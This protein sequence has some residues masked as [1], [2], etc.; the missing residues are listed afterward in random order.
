[1]TT[2]KRSY[3][4]LAAVALASTF[5]Q[6]QFPRV[7]A[8][9]FEAKSG[10][11]TW[12]DPATPD[13]RQTYVSSRGDTWELVMSDEFNMANRS[14]ASGDDHI[15]TSLE[16]P[17]GV[18]AALEV[19]SHNMTSTA[20][21]DDGTCY[22][23]IK[24]VDEVTNVTVWND[25]ASP[26][27]YE[28]VT[29]YYRSGM[30]QSWNKFC[31]QGG[32]VE[33]RAQLPG[34]VSSASGNPDLDGGSSARAE[35]IK[36][37][38]TWPGIWMMGN[39][40][41]AIFSAST[42]RMWPFSYDKCD[43]AVFNSTNQRISACD[44]DP[45][46]GLN[47]NQGRGA[48]EIDILEGG[49]SA[50]S[51]SVQVGPGMPTDF[52]TIYPSN[53]SSSSCI[54]TSTCE[55]KGA[56]APGIPAAVYE[57]ARPDHKTWYQGMRYAANNFCT[58]SSKLKQSYATVKAALAKGVT[59]NAC[60][61][62]NCPASK[63]PNAD[64]GFIDNS[65]TTDS[66]WGINSNGTCFSILNAY[67][68]AYLC[69]P[70][71]PSAKCEQSDATASDTTVTF[72]YQMDAL[73]ANWD[74]H[75]A[76]Y[77]GYLVY[78][79]EWVLG[80]SDGYI[81]WML[82]GQPIFEIPAS[83]LTNPSQD[84]AKSNPVKTMIAEPMYLILNVALSSTWGATPPNAGSKCRGDGTDAT[85]NKICDEF[86]M[87]MKIDYIR[88]YQDTASTNSSMAVGCDPASHPTAQWIADHIDAYQD[89]DN[90]AVDV[91]GRAF[92]TVDDDCTISSNKTK[93]STGSCV[94]SRCKCSSSS[95]TGPRCTSTLSTV[96]GNSSG[97]Y[98][99]PWYVALGTSALTIFVSL[100][101][102]YA[103]TRA[104]KKHETMRKQQQRVM[105]MSQSVGSV[106]DALS[107]GKAPP[108][109]NDNVNYS[110][111]FV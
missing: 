10:I 104:D 78:Q 16:K 62:T 81:R 72:E 90:Q 69:S 105:A 108:I 83:T 76:A 30:V 57:A 2:S 49:G 51:A 9:E 73:S 96:D 52:R 12:V 82:E 48:P 100:L 111:N 77:T 7:D 79:L 55:T 36:Y 109:H 14:F 11:R 1:M 20:C 70:G 43:D 91:S 41:R 21:D 103:T 98:G 45:G 39:L 5:S 88:V 89:S 53:D 65:T 84:A 19:Y 33:V 102:V 74:I 37:Y 54:Y 68:G 110:T 50:I 63:D 46:S 93:V 61:L 15:W 38:P 32:L 18:N 99:P 34:A 24:S 106:T 60:T 42:S 17:D 101:A 80:D 3:S 97:S 58:T 31:F 28:T 22:F 25:Y 71:N 13:D 86:P 95:W 4:A 35:T 23:Y 27:G 6:Q 85:A 66:H 67:S 40:G 29:F 59:D 75:V 107:I 92:C 47:P 94:D 87:F 56:N 8:A 64:L 44:D 26:A